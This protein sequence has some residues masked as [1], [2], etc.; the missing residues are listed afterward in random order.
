MSDPGWDGF[1][2]GAEAAIAAACAIPDGEGPRGFRLERGAAGP[3][4]SGTARPRLVLEAWGMTEPE[5]L[6]EVARAVAAVVTAA[7]A[8]GEAAEAA[9]TQGTRPQ[10]QQP[11]QPQQPQQR[12]QR[13]VRLDAEDTAS[14]LLAW[15]RQLVEWARRDGF[16]ADDGALELR[17]PAGLGG[18]ASGRRWTLLAPVSWLP[19][20]DDLFVA[21]TCSRWIARV[22]LAAQNP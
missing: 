22:E 8:Q 16:V 19:E 9:E 11:Q 17:D 7:G 4:A 21:A 13:I 1:D 18:T 15:I 5:L 6:V 10:G 12:Q 3:G 2:L 14:R 20:P